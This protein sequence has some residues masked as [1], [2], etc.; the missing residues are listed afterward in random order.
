MGMFGPGV[1]PWIRNA[2]ARDY[3]PDA[4]DEAIRLW[5]YASMFPTMEAA[6][7]IELSQGKRKLTYNADDETFCISAIEQADAG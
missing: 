2:R 3:R 6:V 4:R 5:L 1:I 7:L